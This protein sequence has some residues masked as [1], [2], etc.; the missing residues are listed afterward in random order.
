MNDNTRMIIIL[1]FRNAKRV[2]YI[3]A[4][5]VVRTLNRQNDVERLHSA[6]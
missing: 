5:S 4:K 6:G 1:G 3:G 2:L